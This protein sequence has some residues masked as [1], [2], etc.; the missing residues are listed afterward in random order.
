MIAVYWTELRSARYSKDKGE[1]FYR[2]TSDPD[3]MKRLASEGLKQYLHTMSMWCSQKNKQFL[4]RYF[5]AQAKS[6]FP[7]NMTAESSLLA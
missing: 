4:N 2:L 5:A 6:A 7:K 1:I 3:L